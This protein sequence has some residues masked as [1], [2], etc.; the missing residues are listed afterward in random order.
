MLLA[1]K[2]HVYVSRKTAP[3]EDGKPSGGRQLTLMG[4]FA[5]AAKAGD[6]AGSQSM[7]GLGPAQAA[8]LAGQQLACLDCEM[9]CFAHAA[10]MPEGRFCSRSLQKQARPLESP[11]L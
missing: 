3:G 2:A 9:F 11:V 6:A 10:A 7:L 1:D 4:S 5:G 8:K